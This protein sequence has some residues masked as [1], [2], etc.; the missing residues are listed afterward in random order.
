MRT[1]AAE[2]HLPR[3]TWLDAVVGDEKDALYRS[4]DLFV[5]PTHGENFGLV[6]AEAL[7]H[8]VPVVTSHHAPWE[9]LESQGCGWWVELGESSLIE[10]LDEAM[11]LPAETRAAMGA[12]GRAWIQREFAWPPI[13]HQLLEVYR[14]AVGGGQ[15]PSSVLTD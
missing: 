7:A 1:L 11:R 3:L 5:L 4:A 6:V 12:R 8:G 2:L 9:G 13:A 15:P 14:W 10:A